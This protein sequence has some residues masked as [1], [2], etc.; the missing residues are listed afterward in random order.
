MKNLTSP[1]ALILFLFLFSCS[2]G[3]NNMIPSANGLT[4]KESN[5]IT[6]SLPSVIVIPSDALLKRLGC[7][8]SVDNQG[9]NSFIRDYAN[10]F[11]K[12][13]ELRFVIAEIEGQFAKKGFPLENLEQTLKQLNNLNAMDE[14]E[15]V[16]RD[17]R[18]ELMNTARPDYIVELDYE[19]KQDPSSRN[20]DKSLTYIVKCLDVYTNKSISSVT[21]AN[22]G[23]SSD[24][25][26]IPGL[27]KEDFGEAID[28]LSGG[29]TSHFGDLLANGIEITL[30]V[31]TMNTSMVELEDDCGDEEIGE[32]IIEWLK[33]NTV[34]STYKMSKNTSTEMFFT[35]VRIYTED[36]NGN[37]YT[38]YDFAKDIKKALKKG[39]GL[40]VSNKTQSLGDAFLQID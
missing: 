17:L 31:A 11:V 30:R 27:V 24:I 40:S 18:S 9:V 10:S 19:L 21:R 32:K 36:E 2:S 13:S 7:L 15:G 22:A 23:S 37:S 12:S 6:K 14:M 34:N 20:L 4:K 26:D 3:D 25:N 29:I 39:C 5:A 1:F 16:A 28:E 8:S 33:V 35:N 38:A